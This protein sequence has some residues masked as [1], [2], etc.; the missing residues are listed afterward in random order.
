MPV[1]LLGG[2]GPRPTLADEPAEGAG[3]LAGAQALENGG[4][5]LCGQAAVPD[6]LVEP[7]RRVPEADLADGGPDLVRAGGAA[8]MLGLLLGDTTGLEH[9]VESLENTISIVVHTAEVIETRCLEAS[10]IVAL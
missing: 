5:F 9:L 10:Q 4:G 8:D 2:S 3:V 1:F 7:F 6:R